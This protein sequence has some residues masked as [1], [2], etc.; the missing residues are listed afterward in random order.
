MLIII[1]LIISY[2]LLPIT[3]DIVLEYFNRWN[4]TI[5]IIF[6]IPGVSLLVLLIG[7][8][9]LLIAVMYGCVSTAIDE[10]FVQNYFKE[11]RF[12]D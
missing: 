2:L 10:K 7:G 9:I 3:K 1:L 5:G 8:I 11:E 4:K 12:Y 6:L